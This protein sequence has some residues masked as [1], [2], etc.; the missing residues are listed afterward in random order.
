M[1][2][3]QEI[4]D[5]DIPDPT[6]ALRSGYKAPLPGG[7]TLTRPSAGRTLDP[8]SG[9]YESARAGEKRIFGPQ[10][11]L[12]VEGVART[13]FVK[14]SSDLSQ[15]SD[16]NGSLGAS[17][18]SVIDGESAYRL[19][20]SSHLNASAGTTSSSKEVVS[21][22]VEEDTASKVRIAWKDQSLTA[23]QE[24]AVDFDFGAE[25][26]ATYDESGGTLGT[27]QFHEVDSNGFDGNRILELRIPVTPDA[28]GNNRQTR[29]YGNA[30]T[31]DGE[32]IIHHVQLEEARNASLPIVTG[33][34]EVTRSADNY[35]ISIGDWYRKATAM[36]L[37]LEF[38][39]QFYDAGFPRVL[40]AKSVSNRLVF[41]GESR[42]RIGNSIGSDVGVAYN[43]TPYN[44]TK[45]AIS[46]T[47][48][49]LAASFD[50]KEGRVTSK[51]WGLIKETIGFN[52]SIQASTVLEEMRFIPS[53]LS[54]RERNVL[55]S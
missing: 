1:P 33:S 34:S 46:Y 17:A 2:T 29:I 11:G 16:P 3:F 14:W 38:T 6:W 39:H 53:F 45:F 36:T 22:F 42:L 25:S 40:T 54:I 5:T 18:Q 9:L 49:K 23:S 8:V 20:G 7:M 26:F 47:D 50:G 32:T 12:L 28:S 10:Q 48:S 37:Y 4:R 55:T 24:V 30:N 43:L 31:G 35:E 27:P 52:I 51:G 15:W 44:K 19:G 41:N 13:N 21:V